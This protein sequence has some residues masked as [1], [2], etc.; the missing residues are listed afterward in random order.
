MKWYSL[1]CCSLLFYLLPLGPAF[2]SPITVLKPAE[3]RDAI[4]DTACSYM[5][6]PY[7]YGG[8]SSTGFDCSGLVYHV[9]IQVLGESVPRTS[10]GLYQWAEPV[11]PLQMQKG[12]LVFFNTTGNISHVGIYIGDGRFIHSASEGPHT[13]V[14]ISSLNEPY[15]K[16]HFA[17]AGRVL[18][19]AEY[20]GIAIGIGAL[21]ILGPSSNP[22]FVYGLEP[23]LSVSIEVPLGN[24]IVR[25]GME[26]RGFW[27]YYTGSVTFPL[28]LSLGLSKTVRIFAGW[29]AVAG[30]AWEPL[31]LHIKKGPLAGGTLSVI[32]EAVLQDSGGT[33]NGSLS[34][35]LTYRL[36]F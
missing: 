10:M 33:L 16:E 6:A 2:S 11:A 9:F 32:G 20:R 1:I 19:P 29:P 26:L 30:L 22:G 25:P 15:W 24:L 23:V 27:N 34:A 3:T 8:I 21:G 13:G 18:P 14:I 31:S 4:V 35:G 36:D 5:G 28:T 7:V 17:G 12:D